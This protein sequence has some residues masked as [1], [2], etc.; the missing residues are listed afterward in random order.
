MRKRLTGSSLRAGCYKSLKSQLY[1]KER[2]SESVLTR[3]GSG[4][5]SDGEG[6]KLVTSGN[7]RE[8]LDPP[9]GPWL[10]VRVSVFI[11][12]EGQEDLSNKPPE[13]AGSEPGRSTGASDKWQLP[14]ALTC[15]VQRPPSASNTFCQGIWIWDIVERLLMF[16][17]PLDQLLE[18]AAL[19]HEDQ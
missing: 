6:W 3:F 11:A 12:A 8:A 16:V 17:H 14:K 19:L 1:W 2:Q 7:R 5:S 9:A 10:Q 4:N 15:R 13:P 18:P